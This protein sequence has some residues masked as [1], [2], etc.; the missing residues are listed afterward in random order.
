[1]FSNSS[2]SAAAWDP[3]LF[4]PDPEISISFGS[5]RIRNRIHNTAFISLFSRR[6]M[7]EYILFHFPSL[8]PVSSIYKFLCS[9]LFEFLR[10]L[11][12]AFRAPLPVPG[13]CC[14]VGICCST[15]LPTATPHL[16]YPP[17]SQ[18]HLK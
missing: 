15:G 2:G 7:Y 10:Q 3:K 4:S 12:I 5:Y 18:H 6:Y 1:M 13:L 11:H 8:F 17:P 16:P 9:H 14:T